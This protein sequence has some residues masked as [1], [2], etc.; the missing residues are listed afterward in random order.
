[1]LYPFSGGGANWG[2]AAYDA[3][4]NL[5]VINMS[6]VAHV[7]HLLPRETV[8]D[9]DEADLQIELGRQ[10]GADFGMTRQVLLSSLGLPCTPP[11][12]GVIAGVDLSSGEIVWRK[13]L[14]TSEEALFGIG[15]P[16]GTPNFG[17]PIVTESGLI[18]IGAAMDDYLRA[19]DVETGAEL[20]K[21]KLPGSGQATPM[22]YELDGRQYVVIY[23][24]GHGVAGTTLND[25]IVAFAL[26]E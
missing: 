5:L 3:S 11:P 6:N 10:D 24:G 14:G 4:R 26:P 7:L 15:L 21:G 17:G 18:F 22:T 13:T 19:F 8:D 12:Y 25:R 16:L 9:I 2:G 23:A 1:M 20:W